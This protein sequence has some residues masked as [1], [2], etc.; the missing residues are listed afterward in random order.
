MQPI[1]RRRDPVRRALWLT[2]GILATL[3][4]LLTM[5]LINK[6]ISMPTLPPSRQEPAAPAGSQSQRADTTPIMVAGLGGEGCEPEEPVFDVMVMAVGERTGVDSS[7][8]PVYLQDQESVVRKYYLDNDGV[9]AEARQRLAKLLVVG[10]HLKVRFVICGS[11]A[12]R[13]LTFV[14]PTATG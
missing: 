13:F 2:I 10:R 7:A 3:V 12:F 14:Q 8:Q 1:Y 6:E 9:P 4:V 5:A 11:G